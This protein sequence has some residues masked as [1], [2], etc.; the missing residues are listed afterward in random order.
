MLQQIIAIIVIL[1][2]LFKLLQQKNKKLITNTEFLFW[3]F[4]WLSAGMAIIFLKQID[5]FV[6]SLGFS[7]SGIDILLYLSV[8]IIFYLVFRLRLHL[9]QLEKNITTIVREIAKK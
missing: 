9:E 1:F 2:F 3:I 7:G 4:F 8:I 5:N 6:L